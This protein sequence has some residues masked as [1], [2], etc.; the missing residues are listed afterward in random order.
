MV[1]R[2]APFWPLLLFFQK[3]TRERWWAEIKPLMGDRPGLN[4]VKKVGTSTAIYARGQMKF[5]LTI[6][7]LLYLHALGFAQDDARSRQTAAPAIGLEVGLKAPGFSS[8]DQFDQRQSNESLTGR[9]GTV[10]LF[11]RSADW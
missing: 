8:I 1:A 2:R 3:S 9:G 7:C 4:T 10:L 6:L 5:G 11:F